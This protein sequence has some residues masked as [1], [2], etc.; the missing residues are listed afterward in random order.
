MTI[1]PTATATPGTDVGVLMPV[2]VHFDDLDPMG[3]LHNGHYQVLVERAW[4]WFWRS[5]G[6]GGKSGLE[7]DG[8]NVAKTFDITYDRP[9]ADIGE[10]AVHLWMQRLGTTSA[11]AGYRVCSADGTTYAHGSRT[12]VRLDRTTMRPTAWSEQV[13]EIARTLGL[14]ESELHRAR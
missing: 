13:A 6:L 4:G 2:V 5:K 9:V 3:L 12:V 7:G 10:Y 14:P 8:F 1:S 11:T